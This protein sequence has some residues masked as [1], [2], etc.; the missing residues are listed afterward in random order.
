[1]Y[2]LTSTMENEILD[3]NLIKSEVSPVSDVKVVRY[4]LTYSTLMICVGML[5]GKLMPITQPGIDYYYFQLIG[6]AFGLV[7]L[8]FG[9]TLAYEIV[10]FVYRKISNKRNQRKYI[11]WFSVL[12]T[13]FY[14]WSF[15]VLAFL[16]HKYLY[17]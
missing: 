14:F 9:L 3:E 1:L 12:E 10:R 17:G 4:T 7:L 2:P 8:A 11:L 16:F 15:I 13:T 5:I 6:N